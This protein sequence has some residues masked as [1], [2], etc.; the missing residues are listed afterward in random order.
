MDRILLK[1][2]FCLFVVP[3][4]ELRAS[5]MVGRYSTTWTALPALIKSFHNFWFCTFCFVC[6][7]LRSCSRTICW[8]D[9]LCIYWAASVPLLKGACVGRSLGCSGPV[10]DW[11]SHHD[12]SATVACVPQLHQEPGSQLVLLLQVI[13]LF[14]NCGGALHP[15]NFIT[16]LSIILSVS[17]K[18]LLG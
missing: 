8:E 15:F 2:L 14:E 12:F 16:I 13:L 18:N 10:A 3:G 1:Y 9:N 17:V 11:W 4:F 5:C 6:M 7:W